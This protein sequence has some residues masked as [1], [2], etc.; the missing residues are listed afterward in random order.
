MEV[1]R[2]EFD[3]GCAAAI[4]FVYAWGLQLNPE[5]VEQLVAAVLRHSRSA[6]SYEEIDDAVAQ[7]LAEYEWD[8]LTFQFSAYHLERDTEEVIARAV[9]EI[10]ARGHYDTIQRALAGTRLSTA[11]LERVV[12]E[13]GQELIRPPDSWW[14]EATVT[15]FGSD[16]RTATRVVVPLWTEEAGRSGLTLELTVTHAAKGPPDVTLDDLRR[17]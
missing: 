8:S 7:Q 9:S 3:R 13:F 5:D 10:I 17:E 14:S 1:P 6:S 4:P 2:E 11:E 15:P 12:M 16:G